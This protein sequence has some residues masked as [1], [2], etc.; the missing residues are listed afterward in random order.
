MNILII[1]SASKRVIDQVVNKIGSGNNY[2]ILTYKKNKNIFNDIGK[3]I[4]FEEDSIRINA[5]R[6]KKYVKKIVKNYSIDYIVGLANDINGKYHL[7]IKVLLS[8]FNNKRTN[9]FNKNC[10]VVKYK[11]TVFDKIAEYYLSYEEVKLNKIISLIRVVYK[12]KKRKNKNKKIMFINDSYAMGGIG[13]LL[14]EWGKMLSDKYDVTFACDNNGEMYTKFKDN[15]RKV[16]LNHEDIYI[17]ESNHRYFIYLRKIFKIEKPDIV[18][19]TGINTTIT[20]PIA[21]AINGV[22]VIIKMLN[23]HLDKIQNCRNM[24][25]IFTY[26][27]QIYMSFI[28]ISKSV[29]A[30]LIELGVDDKKIKIIYG[31]SVS[32]IN[33]IN[34]DFIKNEGKK[35]ILCCSRLSKEKGIEV[36]LQAISLLNEEDLNN[37]LFIIAGNGEEE[38]NLDDLSQKLNI[39]KY[40]KFI[41]YKKDVKYLIDECYITVLTSHTEGL[42]VAILEAM[43]RGKSCI[44]SN[45]GGIPEIINNDCNGYI[46]GD[47]DYKELARLLHYCLNNVEVVERMNR[48]ALITI[49]EKFDIKIIKNNIIEYLNNF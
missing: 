40:V 36:L 23:G 5:Y 38:K 42:P 25:K 4:Y 46:F 2:F 49:K 34:I 31:S 37:S 26:S 7:N 48:N 8:F 18:V 29:R 27:S 35:K 17:K 15:F 43:A 9:L 14:Y 16:Y 24:K 11:L 22:P 32:A 1:H 20:A 6:V 3:E 41:G 39:N 28:A 33:N 30:N 19:V 12:L 45:V 10:D 47:N 21:A 13:T 44:A